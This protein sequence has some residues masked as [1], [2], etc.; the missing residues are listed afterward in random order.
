MRS[1][2][3]FLSALVLGTIQLT[4][5]QNKSFDP[6][7]AATFFPLGQGLKWTYRVLDRTRGT[8]YI[9]SDRVVGPTHISTGH[10]G[11]EVESQYSGPSGL[12]NS[13]IIYF[14][15]NGYLARQ[16]G[17]GTVE[18]TSPERA[19]LPQLLKPDLAWSNSIV[20]FDQQSH[21]FRVSQTHRTFF[22]TRAVEVPAGSF[23]GCIRLES[24]ALYQ[25]SNA[26]DFSLKLKYI[27]W[28]A[29]RVG[30]VKTVVE[31][32]GFF[33]SELWRIELLTFSSSQPGN[34]VH[35]AMDG[36]SGPQYGSASRLRAPQR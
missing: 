11:V 32:S 6:G 22:E 21:G 18:V 15:K 36:G 33:G 12:F 25:S 8:T 27:D 14:A 13:L 34:A 4:S 9:L 20:P 1:K 7:I 5:C 29:P 10:L 28:Y 19:F 26:S 17:I 30:L 35:S 2:M 23:S 24:D 3:I 16:S 31:Q